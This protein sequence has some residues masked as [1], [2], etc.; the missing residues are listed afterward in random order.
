MQFQNIYYQEF[1]SM[2]NSDLKLDQVAENLNIFLEEFSQLLNHKL[3]KHHLKYGE[4]RL[5]HF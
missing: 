5:N 4:H 2:K 1:F 3:K